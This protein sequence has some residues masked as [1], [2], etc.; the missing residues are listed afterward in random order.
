MLTSAF[1]TA[2]D[3]A[4]AALVRDGEV[5]GERVSRAVTV[6]ADADELLRDAGIA[7]ADLD[8]LVVGIGPG[9]FTGVRIGLATAR[10]LALALDLPVAGVSTLD[11]LAAGAPGAVPVI[12]ARRREVFTLPAGSRAAVATGR[13][14]A[15][16]GRYVGDGAVRYRA[17]IEAAGGVVPPDDERAAT[18]R[19]RAPRAA[20]P[21]FG[22]AERRRAALPA[23]PGRRAGALR[24]VDI[25]R[26]A[27]P[28]P[29][30]DRG[31]RAQRLPDAVV[32]VDV[33]RRAGE[34]VVDLPR[35]VRCRRAARRLPD[36]LPLRRRLARDE[37]R[38]R[39]PSTGGAA[40]RRCCSARCSSARATTTGAATRSRCASRTRPRSRSTSAS[41]SSR[42]G[43][44]RGY[45][46]DNREDALI[47]WKDPVQ[48]P[49][50]RLILGI[51]TSATRRRRRSSPETARSSRTSSPP[52]PSFTRATAAS[53]PRS[54]RGVTSSSSRRSY[55]R[56]SRGRRGP[57]R[58]RA[59]R[60]TR[61]PGLDRRAARR[62]LRREGDRLGSRA[63]ARPGRPPARARRLALPRPEPLE[64][65]F[66]CLLASGGHTL[67]LDVQRPRRVRR[68]GT[69]LDDAAGEA[70]DKGAR[71]LGL[72]YPG[73]AAIDRLAR[74]G[75]P[76]AFAF[77]VARVP[78]LDFSFSG[79]K[80]ALLYAVRG[81]GAEELEA[82]RADL[83]ASTSARSCGRS[84]SGRGRPRSSEA[85]RSPS[86]AGSP[87]TRSCGGAARTPRLRRSRS[88]PTTPR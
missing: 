72:G 26:L 62:P 49:A 21:D 75:D 50:A 45:Y 71:L 9:S 25:R 20:R 74:D 37:R 47:M 53:S 43:V 3:V 11:A 82:R 56:R 77:P 17:V 34:A 67:L 14:R 61:G 2:T 19:G 86:S 48:E 13:A 22:P 40:S 38:R 54:R 64:P 1:D 58:R 79:V 60:V 5:L 4:T 32:A 35:R 24:D 7:P 63:S 55:A 42:R 31:D 29:R 51:E 27:A 59:R 30:R 69:T 84:S 81:L 36:R 6:L 15:R 83:A 23:H 46:T 41:A 87:P 10:G 65:P 76:E 80:T 57:R 44:R 8:R 78:G 33:R 88:A 68:L 28:R 39:R 73:G 52:R 70:F 85:S 66:L 18:S 12:D 16:A